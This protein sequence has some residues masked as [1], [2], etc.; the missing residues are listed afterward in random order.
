[1]YVTPV[2]LNILLIIAVNRF[3]CEPVYENIFVSYWYSLCY[4]LQS[5]TYLTLSV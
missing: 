3:A 5:A 2:D 4:T 1:M